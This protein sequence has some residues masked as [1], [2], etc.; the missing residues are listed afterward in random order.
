VRLKACHLWLGLVFTG[1]LFAV[2][3]EA[4]NPD[5]MTPE[6]S[7]AKG[8]QI[9]KQLVEALGGQAYLN[10]KTSECDG[11]FAQFGHNGAL[12]GYLEFK[13]F[14]SYPDKNRTDFAKKGNIIDL[15]AG[16][17]GWTLDR[18][19]VSEEPAPAVA[20]FQEGVKR[21]INNVL[22][23]RLKED[24]LQIRFGGNSV[25]DLKQVDWVE[26]TDA[27]QRQFR[28]A[29]DHSTHLLVRSV[30]SIRDENTGEK[31]NET[32]VYSNYQEKDGVQV[33]MQVTKERDG[34]RVFQAFYES[35]RINPELPADFFTKE[36][37]EKRY[38][39]VGGKK[40]N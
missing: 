30:V 40:R 20:D 2:L 22:R 24:R 19:G 33:P 31:I 36:A 14:W 16:D 32:T 29:V 1:T 12:T 21:N 39:E 6:A 4:Q 13:V 11:R 35:C 27:E 7:E 18:G 15:Y 3:A 34:R 38:G 37:L 8:G 23:Y 26:I 9:L 10:Q 5:M 28:L 25:V 17:E